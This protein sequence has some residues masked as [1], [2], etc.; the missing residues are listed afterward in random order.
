MRYRIIG[1]F[2]VASLVL[3]NCKDKSTSPTPDFTF[4]FDFSE[5]DEGWAAGYADYPVGQDS[6]YELVS[7]RCVLPEPLDQ[8]TFSIKISGWNYSDDLFMFLK[9]KIA[10]ME[11]NTVYDVKIYVEIASQYPYSSGGVG[12]S[13]GGSV[14]VKV[15]ATPTEPLPVVDGE[16]YRMNIDKGSQSDEGQD[17]VMVGHIGIAGEDFVYT[18]IRRD[19]ENRPVRTQSDENGELWLIV[20]TESG[21]MSTTTIYYNTIEA[22]LFKVE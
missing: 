15:G 18:L 4:L 19:N 17:M 11:P 6:L 9:K 5:N 13:P 10:G 7:A 21:F 14:F 12:G 20:G 8:S 16:Y 2:I 1:I 3:I 22:D